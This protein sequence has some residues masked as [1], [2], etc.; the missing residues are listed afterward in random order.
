MTISE[1][2]IYIK[3]NMLT[4]SGSVNSNHYKHKDFI[5]STIIPLTDF[6]NKNVQIS[7]RIWHI[8][9]EIN[10]EKRMCWG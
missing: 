4:K 3:Q 10:N 1:A 2:Q 6:L 7:Q 9:H 8:I 5:E